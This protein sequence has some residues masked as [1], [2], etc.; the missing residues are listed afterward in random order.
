VYG[1]PKHTRNCGPSGPGPGRLHPLGLRWPGNICKLEVPDRAGVFGAGRRPAIPCRRRPRR[2]RPTSSQKWD[3]TTVART[4]RVV[5]RSSGSPFSV[6]QT[7]S[8]VLLRIHNGR[9]WM[10]VR[11]RSRRRR[12]RLSRRGGTE[13]A[14]APTPS[15]AR[16][17]GLPGG[18]A[19]SGRG[20]R[21]CRHAGR[22]AGPSPGS[23]GDRPRRSGP[24]RQDW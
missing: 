18:T 9:T 15:T 16:R 14:G 20:G 21:G 13:Q 6:I 23:I 17:S 2:W 3:R 22:F 19:P 11:V 10:P 4:L 24:F 12:C 5:L 1:D 8:V 7:G